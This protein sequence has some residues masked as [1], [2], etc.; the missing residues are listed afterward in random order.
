MAAD[1]PMLDSLPHC[2]SLLASPVGKGD[3]FAAAYLGGWNPLLGRR[4]DIDAGVTIR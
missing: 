1:V 4:L 3:G 2:S